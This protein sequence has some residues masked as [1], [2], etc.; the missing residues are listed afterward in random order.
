[1]IALEH[2]YESLS[3]PFYAKVRPETLVKPECIRLNHGLLQELN[4]QESVQEEKDWLHFF[5]GGDQPLLAMAYAGHQFGSFVPSLGDG[6]ALLLGEYVD[7]RGER[8]DIQMKG[9][10]RTPF[11]RGGD[12][13][14]WLGAVVREYIV[15]E[16]MFFLGIPTTR[17]LAM[18]KTGEI[19]FRTREE[20][21][22]MLIRVAK[23]HIRIGT[24][25]YFAARGDKKSLIELLNYSCSRHG[26]IS[27]GR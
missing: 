9:S 26:I 5:A 6:R 18:I 16:G 12:G 27:A 3:S 1:M 15:S 19:V 21:G 14:S 7:P 10:G 24:F 17:S 8:R 11:S 20:Q 25:Q 4:L 22:A 13:K 23:S 2:T